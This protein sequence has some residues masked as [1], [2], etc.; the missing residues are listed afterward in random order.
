MVSGRVIGGC[1]NSRLMVRTQAVAEGA[2]ISKSGNPK[3]RSGRMKLGK[4]TVGEQELVWATAKAAVGA[5]DPV[6]GEVGIKVAARFKKGP[7]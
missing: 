7:N 3:G 4:V 2:P 1:S 5:A 6:Q